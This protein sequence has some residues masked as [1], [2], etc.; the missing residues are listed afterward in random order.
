MAVNVESVKIRA[1]ETVVKS[2]L[3]DGGSSTRRK[4]KSSSLVVSDLRGQCQLLDPFYQIIKDR[5]QPELSHFEIWKI[6]VI[7]V[8]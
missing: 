3:G 2:N 7:A 6:Q 8:R 5:S 4:S 1:N